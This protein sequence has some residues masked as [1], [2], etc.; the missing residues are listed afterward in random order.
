MKIDRIDIVRSGNDLEKYVMDFYKDEARYVVLDKNGAEHTV[1][2]TPQRL[3]E[4]CSNR[5]VSEMMS[6]W[7]NGIKDRISHYENCIKTGEHPY[8][9]TIQ[10]YYVIVEGH[11]FPVERTMERPQHMNK[12][13]KELFQNEIK[14]LKAIDGKMSF[15]RI[16]PFDFIVNTPCEIY[17]NNS[18]KHWR[19]IVITKVTNK[20]VF[21]KEI[22]DS[23]KHGPSQSSPEEG[24]ILKISISRIV[25]MN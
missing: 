21:Y 9:T 24:R 14:K 11:K 2:F 18:M 6:A 12:G 5:T 10:Y 20:Y 4:F 19:N 7:E 23:Y 3:A 13:Q 22:Y 15:V 1:Q 8:W 25:Y 17:S 16:V